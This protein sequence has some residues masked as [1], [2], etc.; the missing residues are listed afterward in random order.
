MEDKSK[1]AVQVFDKLADLYLEKY[2]DVSAYHDSLSRWLEL[3]G[4]QRVR[5]LELACGPGNLSHHVLSQKPDWQWLG[6]DLAPRMI[7]LARK[8]NPGAQ[9]EVMD[10]RAIRALKRRF[11]AAIIGFCFPYLD[12]AEVQTLLQDLN[13]LLEPGAFVYISTEEGLYETSKWVTGSRGD[14]VFMH[15]YTEPDLRECLTAA[16]FNTCEV[17]RQSATVNGRTIADLILLAQKKPAA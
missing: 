14:R 8:L 10:V 15:Y 5:V 1:G 13:S 7:E 12:R 4:N 3:L 16:G 9:F 11:D 2:F 6:I 17:Y